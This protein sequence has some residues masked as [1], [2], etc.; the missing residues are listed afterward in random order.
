MWLYLDGAV[1]SIDLYICSVS[2]YVGFIIMALK[3]SLKSS[4]IIPP[5]TI[6][7][8]VFFFVLSALA[9]FSLLCLHRKF[10][11]ILPVE[12]GCG[13]FL[14]LQWIYIL[15]VGV[16]LFSHILILATHDHG[17]SFQFLA[18]SSISFFGGPF[19]LKRSTVSLV[20]ILTTVLLLLLFACD[21]FGDYCE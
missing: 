3:Y 21:C 6:S 14:W 17:R 13:F 15:L 2:Y 12:E 10:E 19:S 9:I 16:W 8:S 11:I 20:R 7:P 1:Y 5:M 18:S 4:M